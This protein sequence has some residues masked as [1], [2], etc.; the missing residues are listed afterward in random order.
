MIK[1]IG[2]LAL[3]AAGYLGGALAE[4]YAVPE[5]DC[6]AVGSAPAEDSCSFDYDGKLDRYTLT[7]VGR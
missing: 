6:L 7:E 4:S 1:A 5:P 3:L 2:A